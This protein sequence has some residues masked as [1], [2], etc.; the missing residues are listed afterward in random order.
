VTVSVEIARDAASL[1]RFLPAWEDLAAHA[2][3]PNPLYE[4]WM[5][6][7]ALEAEAGAD[8]R[9]ALV[10]TRDAATPQAAPKLGG[11]F[12]LRKA[13]RF[14]GLPAAALTSW[15]HRSWLLGTPLLRAQTAHQCLH[16]LLDWARAEGERS[17][18]V[19]FQYLRSDG[20]FHGVLADVLREREAMVAATDTFTRALLRKGSDGETYLAAALSRAL[21]K[22][23]R[24]K[25]RRLAERGVLEHVALRPH[26]DAGRWI[27]EFLRLEAS[28]WKGRRG[29][30]MASREANRRFAT[31][32][33][34]AA[35]GRGRLQLVGVDF[36]GRPIARCCN[37]I[38]GEG[39]YAYRC[40]YD[41]EFAYFSPGVM[42]EVDTILEFHALPGVQW[43][44]SITEPGNA[45]INRLWKD[46]CTIQSVVVGAGPWGEMW[47]SMLPLL[48]WAKRRWRGS[49]QPCAAGDKLPKA[50]AL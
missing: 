14:K 7:P 49:P 1:R 50:E 33:L 27:D 12:P 48:R 3:E 46:R 8:F 41:E 26:D 16:A 29:S 28:G 17:A 45:T 30:A 44:D 22:S 32:A 2:L 38:A 39:S 21:R 25:E 13:V 20:P 31:A 4:H 42:A 43:M 15:R 23:L 37:L 10:W 18:L 36:E 6:L 24:R 9:C 35:F 47:A 5:L 11:L 34:A 19:E 40:A